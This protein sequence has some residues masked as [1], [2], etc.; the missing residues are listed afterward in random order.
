MEGISFGTGKIVKLNK[1]E[2]VGKVRVR[3]SEE[4]REIE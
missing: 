3:M 2:V 1:E 4:D